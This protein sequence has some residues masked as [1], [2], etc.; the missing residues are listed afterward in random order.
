MQFV[1]RYRQKRNIMGLLRVKSK[2]LCRCR[3]PRFD[4][5]LFFIYISRHTIYYLHISNDYMKF[6]NVSIKINDDIFISSSQYIDLNKVSRVDIRQVNTLSLLQLEY[7]RERSFYVYLCRSVGLSKICKKC[8]KWGIQP[9]SANIN[10]F[11]GLELSI[12]DFCF[13]RLS[14][15][16]FLSKFWKKCQKIIRTL[17]GSDSIRPRL[18]YTRSFIWLQPSLLN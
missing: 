3:C 1:H 4:F 6:S 8:K 2:F 9:M 5:V 12:S 14:V 10:C 7:L 15:R 13:V 16:L 11:N 17:N 18:N